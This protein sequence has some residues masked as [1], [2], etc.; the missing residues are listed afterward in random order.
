[1]AAE[2]I[3]AVEWY[4][5]MRPPHLDVFPCPSCWA[6][7]GCPCL[8]LMQPPPGPACCP[9]VLDRTLGSDSAFAIF[10]R[11]QLG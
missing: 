10:S 7:D 11:S 4:Y 3:H 9:G 8:D 6:F 2:N 5:V 1:M